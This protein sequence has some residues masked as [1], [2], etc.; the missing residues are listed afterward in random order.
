MSPDDG[1]PNVW[2]IPEEA[3]DSIKLVDPERESTE[4]W[5]E[6]LEERVEVLEAFAST[7]GTIL[8][9]DGHGALE[10]CPLCKLVRKLDELDIAFGH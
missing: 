3:L 6:M 8:A 9:R 5:I 4:T 10:H 2:R 1:R 7:A